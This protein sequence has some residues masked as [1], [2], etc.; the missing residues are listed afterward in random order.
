MWQCKNFFG[1]QI[2]RKADARFAERA[3]ALPDMSLRQT[4]RQIGARRGQLERGVLLAIHR[5]AARDEMLDVRLPRGDGIGLIQTT[6]RENRVPQFG[7]LR[8]RAED[9]GTFSPPI[10]AA[11]RR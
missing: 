8:S 5:I 3:T 9:S 10:Q 2:G 7:F 6:R 4:D 1:R 11:R